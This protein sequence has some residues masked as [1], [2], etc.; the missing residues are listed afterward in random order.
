MSDD[1]E[2]RDAWRD[3]QAATTVTGERVKPGSAPCAADHVLPER[4]NVSAVTHPSNAAPPAT[5]F[6]NVTKTYEPDP[7]VVQRITDAVLRLEVAGHTFDSLQTEDTGTFTI[8]GETVGEW[9]LPQNSTDAHIV[10]E[11][12][13]DAIDDWL[14]RN[15]VPLLEEAAAEGEA[16]ATEEAA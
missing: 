7:E 9:S 3:A 4:E 8:D 13:A 2:R 1:T 14:R 10:D 12:S 5:A 6:R 16:V 15:D 11:E